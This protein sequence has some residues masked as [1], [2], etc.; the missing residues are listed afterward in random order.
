[1]T[2][3]KVLVVDFGG[4]YSQVIARRVRDEG[5]FAEI[6]PYTAD[7]EQ[8]KKLQPIGII[9]SGGPSS[10]RDA[11]APKPAADLF[12]LEVPILGICYGAQLIAQHF[13]GAVESSGD[14]SEY[15]STMVRYDSVSPLFRGLP[16]QAPAWMSHMDYITRVPPG[17]DIT[18]STAQIPVAAFENS[19]REVYALQFHPEVHHTEHGSEIL[20]N[21][22]FDV[23]GASGDWSMSTYAQTAEERIREKVGNGKVLLALSGGVDSSVCAALLHKAVGDALT[24]VF[25]NTGLMRKGEPEEVERVFAEQFHMNL[26]HVNAA[27]RFLDKLQGVTDPEEKRRIIGEEFIRVFESEASKLGKVEFL[28]QGTIYPDVVESGTGP[29]ALIKSH[30]NVGGLPENI[31]FDEI[32]EPLRELFKDEVR[33][34]GEE[35]GLPHSMVWRQP[36]PGPGLAIRI[37]GEVTADKLALV[38]ESDQIFR[39]EIRDA[40]LEDKI[41]QYFTVLTNIRSVGVMGD[42]RTYDYTVALRA[43]DS[44]DAMTADWARIPDDVLARVSSR[45]VN[46]VP[47]INRVVYDITSKPPATI[48]FE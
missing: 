12:S 45:I 3:E 2:N 26:V 11:D 40:G 17:F 19:D 20:H 39:N 31:E 14:R 41:W 4:Q 13:G 36:F 25:V 42:E 16:A 37:I 1:M 7:T 29:A 30:H 10:V 24:C 21:F 28:A 47:H 48:E 23:C 34:L 18:A 38:R 46:E 33:K 27:D 43:V 5:V 22:L 44:T 35:L 15:G 9:L 8:L 32:L 6:V